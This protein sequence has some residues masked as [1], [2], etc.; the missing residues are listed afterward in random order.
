MWYVFHNEIRLRG[1]IRSNMKNITYKKGS[2]HGLPDVEHMM[3]EICGRCQELN[4]IFNLK[5]VDFFV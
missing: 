2:T 1:Y 5:G 3:F 4:Y